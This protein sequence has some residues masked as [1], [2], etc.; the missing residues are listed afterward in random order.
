M[1]HIGYCILHAFCLI[2]P[3][4]PVTGQNSEQSTNLASEDDLL[5]ANFANMP[6]MP[7]HLSISNNGKITYDAQK[8]SIV[9]GG[10]VVVRADN[11][12]SLKAGSV[13]Y[14]SD[15]E[16]AFL[17]G[18]VSVRQK[19]TT[20]QNGKIIPGIQLFAEKVRLN[21]RDTTI[22]LSD[23]VTIYQGSS[24]HH[25]NAATYN[26]GTGQLNTEGLASGHDYILMQS[27]RF[28]MVNH[29][30][31]KVFIGENA[32]I[33]THDV[34]DPNYWIRADKT[35]IY[36][37]DRVIFNNLRLYAGD[38]PVLWLPYL[39]QPLDANLGYLFIPGARSNWGFYLLNRYGVMLG[40]EVDELTGEREG[41][42]LRSQWHANLMSKRGV[43][44]GLDLLDTRVGN[45]ENL[46]GLKLFFLEDMDP[47]IR[48]TA[49][50][51]E[52]L[53]ASRWKLELK[54]RIELQEKN[55][56][57]TY[58]NFDITALSDRFFLED[59]EQETFKI[60][61]SPDNIAGIF[62]R[63]PKSLSGLYTRMRL[64]DF[65]QQD[66]RLP[67]LFFDQVKGPFFGSPVLHEGN[68]SLGI[69]D[70]RLADYQID[71]LEAE[72]AS[73][74]VDATRLAEINELL[75]DRGYTR[76]HTWHEFSLPLNPG[77]KVA[78][79][80]RAGIGYTRYTDIDNGAN[81]F[82]RTH[83]SAGV[84]TSVKFSKV[85]P[86]AVSKTWGLDSILHVLQ[87]Y[88]NFSQLSTD[89]LDSSF[90]GIETLTPST[91]P[92]PLE[93]GQFTAT[94]S[95]MDWSI[96]RL[97]ARNRLLTKR[98]GGSHEW[99]A[100][101]TYMDFF[102]NDPEFDRD[103]SNLYN[104]IIWQPL[105]WM[106]LNVETQF[107]IAAGGSEFR[108]WASNIT[109][110]P[111]DVIELSFGYRQLDNHPI[112][113]DSNRIDLRAYARISDTWGLGSY[114][115]WE[116]DDNTLEVQQY[117]IYRD[118]ESWIASVGLHIRDN[119]D[120]P[121]EFGIMLNFTLKDFPSFRLPLSVDN[122]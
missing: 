69:Y 51:R 99:L 120:A 13:T 58:L 71:N 97:G 30:G 63:N 54:H 75:A 24:I 60:N 115:R 73:P 25:G 15:D 39:S 4:L 113:I 117:N 85:Y 42:W 94:D 9:Y 92:R 20:L 90:R 96:L 23:N 36:P 74:G 50:N 8:Q 103:T 68:T 37:G 53:D 14:H 95:L 86:R 108:E 112:L 40:G 38:I 100:V 26:Y 93:V 21:A 55:Q 101:D 5:G 64:N 66:T 114:Q 80:P 122:E 61:P 105:P 116:L 78:I 27:N 41:A 57:Q 87:T 11:G 17:R 35:S 18:H 59:F 44:M 83:M 111:N 52:S 62:H 2:L 45:E 56:N 106:R 32:G 1:R 121:E 67:E 22:T 49:E 77:G 91:R 76:L 89:S 34:S 7:E 28:R 88:A 12:I 82:G 70:E 6:E 47:T 104:D 48:R 65:Y 109:F 118:F 72:A 102:M 33:T 110:M 10:D 16:T 19:S 107:P 79:T 3:V 31:K 98:D 29:K 119:R 81:S 46:S 84:D 43:G